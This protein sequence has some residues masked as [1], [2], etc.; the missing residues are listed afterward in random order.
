MS[1]EKVER[2]NSCLGV[3]KTHGEFGKGSLP[4]ALCAFQVLHHHPERDALL[5]EYGLP[6]KGGGSSNSS[7]HWIMRGLMLLGRYG[8]VEYH[9]VTSTGTAYVVGNH[10]I[11]PSY[12]VLAY[13]QLTN[14][15]MQT[16][17]LQLVQDRVVLLDKDGN[18]FRKFSADLVAEDRVED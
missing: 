5:K 16:R 11:V 2:S 18:E 7:S 4:R 6:G 1:I 17:R 3:L 14:I 8:V 15:G 9:Y 10:I 13:Y 12:P